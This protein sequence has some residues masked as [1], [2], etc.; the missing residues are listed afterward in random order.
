MKIISSSYHDNRESRDPN[1]EALIS[2]LCLFPK[3]SDGGGGV[4]GKANTRAA[5][6]L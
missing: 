5:V 4:E 3:G 6:S 1:R 2:H